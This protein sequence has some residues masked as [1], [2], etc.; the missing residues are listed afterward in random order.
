MNFCVPHINPNSYDITYG[1]PTSRSDLTCAVCFLRQSDL[2]YHFLS[3]SERLYI[4]YML[5]EDSS[6]ESHRQQRQVKL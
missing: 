1:R 3:I 6:A 5:R 4:C 2:I